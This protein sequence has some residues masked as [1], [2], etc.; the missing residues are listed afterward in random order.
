MFLGSRLLSFMLQTYK[1]MRV[2]TV[3]AISLELVEKFMWG[4]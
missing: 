3:S 1:K 2:C 4:E